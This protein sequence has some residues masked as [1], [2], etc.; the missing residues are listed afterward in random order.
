M[1]KFRNLQF[2]AFGLGGLLAAFLSVA[3]QD[4]SQNLF[5][6]YE[7]RPFDALA[8]QVFQEPDLSQQI[9]ID[10]DGTANF[11]LVGKVRIG[12]MTVEEATTYLF[13]RYNADYLVNP[14][15]SLLVTEYA[16]REVQVLGQVNQPGPV[17]IPVDRELSLV[18]AIAAASGATRLANLRDVSVRRVLEDGRN[19]TFDIDVQEMITKEKGETFILQH[20]DIIFIPER[21]F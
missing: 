12:G 5:Q 14:Q 2:F 13:E 17:V 1:L 20:K 18:E 15:I 3:G 21:T 19:V 8:F 6:N 11:P 9:R 4:S 7:L 16:P 10:S